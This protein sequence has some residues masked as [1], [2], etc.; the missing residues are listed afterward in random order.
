MWDLLRHGFCLFGG[1][2]I[3]ANIVGGNTAVAKS[4]R[5]L[6]RMFCQNVCA[7]R[8]ETRKKNIR[9]GRRSLRSLCV[10]RDRHYFTEI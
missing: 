2:G 3:N 8:P 1:W 9:R 5:A 6:S 10:Q 4:R 7:I